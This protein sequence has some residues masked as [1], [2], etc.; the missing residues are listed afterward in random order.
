V[1]YFPSQPVQDEID[2]GSWRTTRVM[3]DGVFIRFFDNS[4][5]VTVVAEGDL[6][7]SKLTFLIDDLVRKLLTTRGAL[8]TKRDCKDS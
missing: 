1:G 2:S 4:D 7:S 3:V 8:S 5:N 6:E